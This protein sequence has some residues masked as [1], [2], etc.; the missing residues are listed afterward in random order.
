[1]RWG[2][3]R[4][5][6]ERRSVAGRVRS[7]SNLRYCAA[8]QSWAPLEG[9]AALVDMAL[10]REG[11]DIGVDGLFLHGRP[12]IS[13]CRVSVR[14]TFSVGRRARLC[15]AVAERD[16]AIPLILPVQKLE[17]RWSIVSVNV[18]SINTHSSAMS[19]MS[20]LRESRQCQLADVGICLKPPYAA[21][22]EK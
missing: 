11:Y 17:D 8:L 4:G 9:A 14:A 15:A 21:T 20:D 1:M 19:S 5:I 16:L 7:R 3:F 6:W 18:C 13:C 22:A 2:C 10:L 12:G